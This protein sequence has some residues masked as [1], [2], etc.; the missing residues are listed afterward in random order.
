MKKY[1]NFLLLFFLISCGNQE[2]ELQSYKTKLAELEATHL[3][4]ENKVKEQEIKIKTLKDVTAKWDKDALEITNKDLKAQTKKLNQTVAEN[5]M[6]KQ[7]D[8]ENFRKSFVFSLPNEFLQ[9]FE[10]V[11]DKYKISSAMNP[12]YTTGY[13]DTDDKLDYAVFIENKQNNKQGVAV[14]K[15]SDYSKFYIL[16]AGNTLNDG[17]D[18]LNG[19]LALTTLNT[20]LVES[21]GENPAPQIKSLN[22]ISLSFTNFSSAVAYLDE[23]EFKLYAQAD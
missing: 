21:R 18:D 4:L 13:F 5:A 1:T 15:G 17:S 3:T 2:Q 22:V 6:N 11:S 8:P 9:A 7:V 12:F 19:L 20:N 23:G 16:G 10:S 14:I